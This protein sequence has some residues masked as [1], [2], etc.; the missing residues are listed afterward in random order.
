MSF[1]SQE[2]NISRLCNIHSKLDRIL[3]FWD[4]VGTFPISKKPLLNWLTQIIKNLQSVL[5]RRIII[6]TNSYI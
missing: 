6:S 3:P 5:S 1:T 4:N 2:H